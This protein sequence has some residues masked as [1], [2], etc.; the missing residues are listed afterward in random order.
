[1]AHPSASA[2]RKHGSPAKYTKHQEATCSS[3]TL[4]NK[5]RT[6]G[7]SAVSTSRRSAQRAAGRGGKLPHAPRRPPRGCCS[8][9][10][11]R[12]GIGA[13]LFALG[14]P[15]LVAGVV[16]TVVAATDDDQDGKYPPAFLAV[17]PTLLVCAFILF[18]S[19][20]S[21]IS[22]IMANA[23]DYCF[24]F[25]DPNS[26]CR[27]RCPRLSHFIKPDPTIYINRAAM[28]ALKTEPGKPALKK[29]SRPPYLPQDPGDMAGIPS[30]HENPANGLEDGAVQQQ[31][32]SGSSMTQ[33][34]VESEPKVRRPGQKGVRFSESDLD[35][36]VRR[37]RAVS[38]SSDSSL[39]SLRH[40]K[41]YPK[42]G[43]GVWWTDNYDD[44]IQ[45]EW[46]VHDKNR[47]S[48]DL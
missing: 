36:G 29:P 43:G 39:L 22:P 48:T 1:M 7:I 2:E 27:V 10:E 16:M 45:E 37:P 9:P 14:L 25:D 32:C 40:C 30:A 18:L 4:A 47:M 33:V 17:G 6:S 42:N 35:D 38:A 21:L 26:F 19:G 8:N 34:T 44:H 46:Q 20:F 31:G 12:K 41:I 15:T 23:V 5:T 11:V 13:V 28:D 3:P 24:S